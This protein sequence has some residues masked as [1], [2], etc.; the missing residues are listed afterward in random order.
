MRTNGVLSLSRG[1]EARW[2]TC[3]NA[4][5]EVSRFRSQDRGRC[6]PRFWS[7]P[8]C[9]PT[10]FRANR[11]AHAAGQAPA[12]LRLRGGRARLCCWTAHLAD[13]PVCRSGV[14]GAARCRFPCERADGGRRSSRDRPEGID[15]STPGSARCRHRA[16]A[17]ASAV[18]PVGSPE[19]SLAIALD[20][21]GFV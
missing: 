7:D 2:S 13:P 16:T 11:A 14:C 5:H 4:C 8:P 17:P 15:P 12:G 9:A 21:G 3:D 20:R 1:I 19:L 6:L 18:D 10:G